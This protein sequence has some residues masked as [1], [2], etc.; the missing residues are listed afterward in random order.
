MVE[1]LLR[2]MPLVGMNRDEVVGLLG[3]PTRSGYF[4][5]YDLVYWLGPEPGLLSIDSEWLVMK[6]GA[7]GRVTVVLVMTD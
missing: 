2:R 3:E 4:K 5:D 1:D 6:L 7:A